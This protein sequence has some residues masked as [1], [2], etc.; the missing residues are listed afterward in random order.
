MTPTSMRTSLVRP[1][2]TGFDAP[3]PNSMPISRAATERSRQRPNETSSQNGPD[4]LNAQRRRL[5]GRVGPH[6]VARHAAVNRATSH[7]LH[8]YNVYLVRA[9]GSS[10]GCNST[11]S[12]FQR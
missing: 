2:E 7:V 12:F 1:F 10:A 5:H 8:I 3:P 4:F 6:C 9:V 11:G